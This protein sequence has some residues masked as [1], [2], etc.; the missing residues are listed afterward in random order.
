MIVTNF[1]CWKKVCPNN[2]PYLFSNL[3]VV[4][5]FEVSWYRH[6][7]RQAG[8][9]LVRYRLGL[10]CLSFIASCMPLA[11]FYTVMSHVPLLLRRQAYVLVLVG[12]SLFKK[13]GTAIAMH[14]LFSGNGSNIKSSIGIIVQPFSFPKEER[15][16][17]SW[18]QGQSWLRIIE[19]FTKALKLI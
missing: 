7:G 1:H 15:R 13:K 18:W 6:V 10:S 11:P 2:Q 14:L 8:N 5:V 12:I 4:I 9:D 16:N 19:L 17:T 3:A